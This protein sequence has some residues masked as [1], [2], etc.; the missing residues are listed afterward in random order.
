MAGE[1]Q[2]DSQPRG[3][4]LQKVLA[5]AGYGS[6]REMEDK[7]AAGWVNVNGKTAKLGDRVTSRDVIRYAGR[8]LS[9]KRLKTRK[10]RVIAYN[11]REGEVC[12]R[13]DPEKRKTVFKNLPKIEGQRWISVGRLDINSSGL[14]LFTNDGEVANQLMHP[15]GELEREYAVRVLG[16]A[17]DD[18][19]ERLLS[20]VQLEDGVFSFESIHDERGEGANRWYNVTLKE[21]RNRQVRKLFESQNIAVNR[22]IRVRYGNVVLPNNLRGGQ[23]RELSA[24]EI[25]ALLAA[26][27]R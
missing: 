23:H 1:N 12:T 16:Q 14:L 9:D 25:K 8:T 13:R 10:L 2:K 21:G 11:K 26:C 22:L 6:R 20:G 3:E 15:R 7:I 19:I 17:T 27:K 18:A 5:R 24:G 4:K